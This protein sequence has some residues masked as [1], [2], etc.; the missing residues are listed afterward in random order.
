MS[1][2]HILAGLL[3]AGLASCGGGGSGGDTT[4]GTPQNAILDSPLQNATVRLY[5]VDDLVTALDSTSSNAQGSYTL[6]YDGASDN[7]YYLITVT[8]GVDQTDANAGTLHAL[9]PGIK[10][11][12]SDVN[13]TPLSD[14]AW[15]YSEANL[16]EMPP[17]DIQQ[18]LDDIAAVLLAEDINQDGQIDYNDVL[19][20]DPLNT[21][22]TAALQFDYAAL[23]SGNQPSLLALY[24]AGDTDTVSQRLDDVFGTRLSPFTD[25]DTRSSQTVVRLLSYGEGDVFSQDGLITFD[26]D[27]EDGSAKELLF[28][29]S[30][31]QI[32]L[33]ATPKAGSKI[34]A[35][36]G[37]DS[38]SEDLSQCTFSL[39]ADRKIVVAFAYQTQDIDPNL[40]DL[41]GV[42]I[43]FI[44]EDTLAASFS[45]EN[46]SSR[47]IDALSPGDYIAGDAGDGFL[48]Q[49]VSVDKLS[50][51]EFVIHT[52]DA[53]LED[54][55]E[56][57]SFE[58]T[59]VMT[60]D[61]LEDEPV[62]AQATAT[63]RSLTAREAGTAA[64]EGIDG[65]ELIPSDD[66][67]SEIF[68]LRIGSPDPASQQTATRKLSDGVSGSV[69]GSVVLIS[70]N[71]VDQVRARGEIKVR[72]QLDYGLSYKHRKV[73]SIRFIPIVTAEEAL[74]L[75]VLTGLETNDKSVKVGT[76]SFHK[77]RLF[78]LVI[79]PKLDLYLGMDG[80]LAGKLNTSF[81]SRQTL[82]AGVT[83]NRKS[84]F[85]LVHD[86]SSSTD[87][88]KYSE[89]VGVAMS[90]HITARPTMLLYG[91]TGPTI[92]LKAYIKLR[93]QEF[94]DQTSNY[95]KE[96]R[97][98]TG[99]DNTA[100]AGVEGE[101]KWVTRGK[102]RTKIGRSIVS[103]LE[104]IN[105]VFLQREWQVARWEIG[106]GCLG[107]KRPAKLEALQGNNWYARVSQFETAP[108]KFTYTVANVGEKEL[109][110]KAQY[111]FSLDRAVTLSKPEGVLQPGTF[112]EVI[113][114]V[115]PTKL[116]GGENWIRVAFTNL[117]SVPSP[118]SLKQRPGDDETGN[119]VLKST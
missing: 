20:F 52:S 15:V 62:V 76:I 28:D 102:I 56:Q 12:S 26:S 3:V 36:T 44:D 69:D 60:N 86:A 41:S 19:A 75:E 104:H 39:D 117:S 80:K 57:G 5:R 32:Q 78:P 42:R 29:K 119:T 31:Q 88:E 8:G 16:K 30:A 91:K 7:E 118:A 115:D 90:S 93:S 55:V 13:V 67:D 34:S 98:V 21:Q 6:H 50:P 33:T 51:I 84:G 92:P 83:Y 9:V 43:T 38:V 89:V 99:L 54:V 79:R 68:T 81:R 64:F 106:A 114:T 18:R 103:R 100:W 101:I 61:D 85:H 27:Q 35:W 10:L 94:G 72:V 110:W 53:T 58:F 24:H 65:V 37:C 14:I 95:W 46:D 87:F 109:H 70:K 59:K 11:S 23:L 97:C 116:H 96:Q 22:H 1:M 71:G 2:K 113:A 112:E 17:Q 77:I 4:G 107:P 25:R 49:V 66:P 108:V 73:T 45:E 40:L 105:Q 47:S 48:R 74:D 63:Q 82:K 111:V